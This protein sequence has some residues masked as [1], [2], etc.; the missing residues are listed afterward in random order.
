LSPCFA[1]G[2]VSPPPPVGVVYAPATP[3]GSLT[4]ARPGERHGWYRVQSPAALAFL[5]LYVRKASGSV[6]EL[7]LKPVQF[8]A[9]CWL[10]VAGMVALH[11]EQPRKQPSENHRQAP[12][13]HGPWFMCEL[14]VRFAGDF[15]W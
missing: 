4:G 12:P 11:V 9:S 2:G 3:H 6:G 1:P 7:G 10:P 15:C 5:A 8:G 13:T 14:P